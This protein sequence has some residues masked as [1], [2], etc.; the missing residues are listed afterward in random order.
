[1]DTNKIAKEIIK[2]NNMNNLD[3]PDIVKIVNNYRI[4]LHY[5]DLCG[6]ESFL[7]YNSKKDNFEI[8][9]DKSLDDKT[10]RFCIAMEFS[11]YYLDRDKIKNNK[12]VYTGNVLSEDY[13]SEIEKDIFD[14]ATNLLIPDNCFR[15]IDDR[16][17]DSIDSLSS[18]YAVDESSM[19]Y[20]ILKMTLNKNYQ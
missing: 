13:D 8:H 3:Y 19:L 6:S 9:V 20:K 12:L 15:K 11:R 2:K 4:Y 17:F 18:K 14:L 7:K 10:K 5:G 16:T 1:M